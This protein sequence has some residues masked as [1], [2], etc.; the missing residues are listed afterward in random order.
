MAQPPVGGDRR[1]S[2]GATTVDVVAAPDA[3]DLLE[4]DAE[5]E[6]LAT[7]VA[8]ARERRGSVVLVHGEAG[9][10]K[11]TLLRGWA[12]ALDADVRLLVGWA[13][14][15]SAAR[16]FAPLHD[17]ARTV[18]EDLAAALADGRS[19]PVF[20]AVLALLDDPLRVTVLVL[21]DVHWADDAT[22][23]VV[24]HVVRR[25]AT[26]P[27][28]L[29]LTFRDE[30]LARD[31]A[32]RGVLGRLGG[33]PVHRITPA[34]LTLD[35]VRELAAGVEA[36]PQRVL[37]LT[38]GN[39]FL[40]AEVLAAGGAVSA[41]VTDAVLARV[42][43][44]SPRAGEVV[45]T[46]SVVPG[47]LRIGLAE[48]VAGD[49]TVLAEAERRGVLH[50][51]TDRVRFRHELLRHAIE[52]RLSLTERRAAHRAVLAVQLEADGWSPGSPPAQVEDPIRIVHSAIGAGD[53]VVLRSLGPSAA[54]SANRSGAHAMADRVESALLE[55]RVGLGD[56]ERAAV[57][58]ARAWTLQSLRRLDEAWAAARAAVA[59]RPVAGD[60]GARVRAE[61]TAARMAYLVNE[62]VAARDRVDVALARAARTDDPELEVEAT[63]ARST[64]LT[65]LEDDEALVA[66]DAAIAAA[67]AV[68]REDQEAL[69]RLYRA[70]ALPDVGHSVQEAVDE[71]LV[72]RDVA[73]RSGD[74]EVEARVTM[75]LVGCLADHADPRTGRFVAEA[76]ALDHDG[77]DRVAVRTYLDIVDAAMAVVHGEWERAEAQLAQVD[78]GP[79][80]GV[81]GVYHAEV[82]ARLAV[83]RGDHDAAALLAH[84]LELA[85]ETLAMQYL[86]PLVVVGLEHELLVGGDGGA[87]IVDT[88][89]DAAPLRWL[90]DELLVAL[91]RVGLPDP[92]WATQASRDGP[93]GA[94]VRGEHLVAADGFG[95]RGLRYDRAMALVD[96]G[97]AEAVAEAIEVFDGL[98]ARPAARLARRRLAA[99][100]VSSV[101][102]GPNLTTRA[103]PAGLTDRQLDVFRLVATGAS[104]RD[105]AQRLVVSV[106]TVENHVAAVL[107][108]LDVP[109]REQAARLAEDLLDR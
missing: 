7:A 89:G 66:G 85:E 39:A 17:V 49:V 57:L 102:R 65:L 62:P 35:A 78:A 95:R 74:P 25:I 45:R 54:A 6:R 3:W 84:G 76:R 47:G 21:E 56:E 13:D 68:G 71:L 67:A 80:L 105:I 59:L 38:G 4:R 72:A 91:R 18:G 27:A 40:V 97:E 103:N 69:A 2:T 42:A 92:A 28:V 14:D 81:D 86:V 32:L 53:D 46:L 70:T 64:L 29:V 104:N 30:D 108:K 1:R 77:G 41:S 16:S 36:D 23:D 44:L 15:L 75:N 10:G 43:T 52:H 58:E 26:R 73:R 55:P 50:G 61:L 90:A 9:S 31:H 12:A 96:S 107:R 101:P 79:A 60:V 83:R 98:G 87:G 94:L 22:L 93:W 34:P 99:L 106:R 8:D 19:D 24:S 37:G 100:G 48:Q 109:T 5:L 51:G 88:L 33:V 11:S 20:D 63:V 82:A